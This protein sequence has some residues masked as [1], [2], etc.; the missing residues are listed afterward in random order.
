MRPWSRSFFCLSAAL[1]PA[2]ALAGQ[3]PKPPELPKLPE[4]YDK[5]GILDPSLIS[6]QVV[7]RIE[8]EYR[9]AT[10]ASPAQAPKLVR[11]IEQEL[12]DLNKPCREYMACREALDNGSDSQR[13]SACSKDALDRMESKIDAAKLQDLKKKLGLEELPGS[14]CTE[15]ESFACWMKCSTVIICPCCQD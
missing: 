15:D 9:D 3:L 4:L 14:S 2:L 10:K 12:R 11:D 8:R 6:Q 1:I 5:A 13:A 7:K